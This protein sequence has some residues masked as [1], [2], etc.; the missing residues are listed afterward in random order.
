VADKTVVVRIALKGQQ[1]SQGLKQAAADTNKFAVDV[2]RGADNAGQS[3]LALGAA[4][5]TAGKL[6]VLGIGGAMVVSAAAAIEYQS[7]LT[8]V[9]KTTG[10]AG[11]T[12]ASA[13]SELATFG[14]AMRNLSL[15]I[16][17]NV[18]ELNRIAELGGQLGVAVPS[19][20]GFTETIAMLG[21]TTN[22]ATEEAATGLARF[23]NIMGTPHSEFGRLGDIIVDL[24]N[25]FAATESEI[26]KFATRIAPVGQTV[27]ATEEEVMALATSLTSLG[28]PAERGG[29][30]VQRLFIDMASAIDDAGPKL[31]KFAEVA[32]MT[33]EEF[34][35]LFGESPARAF[36]EFARGLDNVSE[37]GGSAFQTLRELGIN[38]QRTIQV[39]LASASGWETIADAIDTANRAGQEGTALQ[40]E[41][42]LRFGTTASELQLLA[43]AFNDLR[44]EVG[45]AILG[46]G[47]LSVAVDVVREFFGIVKDNLPTIQ[48][49]ATVMG[50]LATVRMGAWLAGLIPQAIQMGRSLMTMASGANAASRGMVAVKLASLGLTTAMY[51]AL[52]IAGLLAIKWANAAIEAAE[53]RRQARLL[54]EEIGQ[55]VDPVDAFVNSLTEADILSGDMVETLQKYGVST[56]DFVEAL[57]EGKSAQEVLNDIQ[58]EMLGTG[59]LWEDE[60]GRLRGVTHEVATDFSDIAKAVN[61]SQDQVEAFMGLKRS[62]LHDVLIDTG[63]AAN[64]T[65]DEIESL[66][67]RALQM[68]GLDISETEF[69]KWVRG[70]FA[71]DGWMAQI[72]DM[73]QALQET[74]D[75]KSW[76]EKL[77]GT[78]EGADQ[79]GDFF[80][81]IM[82][83]LG[84]YSEFITEKMD[85]VAESVYSQFPA[86]DEY[87]QV[88]IESLDAVIAAQDKFIEDLIVATALEEELRGEL[89]PA[90]LDWFSNLDTATQAGLARFREG[91]QTA[92]DQFI[93]DLNSNFDEAGGVVGEKWTNRLPQ[94][95]QEGFDM[96]IAGLAENVDAMEL[97]GEDNAEAFRDGLVE[98]LAGLPQTHQPL[99][100]QY[101]EDSLHNP[102]LLEG[103]G[104]DMGDALIRGLLMALGDMAVRAY[105]EIGRQTGKIRGAFEDGFMVESPSKFTFWIGTQLTEGLVQGLTQSMNTEASRI[106]RSFQPAMNTML[107]S[108]SH[109][110]INVPKQPVGD[111]A[112]TYNNPHM[113]D[114][115]KDLKRTKLILTDLVHLTEG[116]FV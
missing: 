15:D 94:Y 86:W 90:A 36:Q 21:V 115:S 43:N 59:E 11:E 28:V 14:Q 22:L 7:S 58:A 61:R 98:I 42:A 23:A 29:T 107:N 89:S 19:L 30:A 45:N 13:G 63:K 39:L 54:N 104:F 101:L 84:E 1:F 82:D 20:V 83:G 69:G 103:L 81:S 2:S 113:V 49:L 12:F 34:A 57:L 73:N 74:A 93:D 50:I 37:S 5:A 105:G 75:D 17:I 32:G 46:S 87:E 68:F 62:E 40:E 100:M 60:A 48:N 55:G 110:T 31:E 102:A 3:A 41:A 71:I 112:L 95:A 79:V 27:G 106:S 76:I 88:V 72:G 70:E 52:A 24:G 108:A 64:M 65:D 33:G 4:S 85:E 53:L 44:I 91:N 47:G 80:G 66:I 35:E 96:M 16:P 18:N 10:L 67:D 26:L 25:N 111:I 56:R 9:A 92:F 8:G 38:E 116:R 6:M 99:F 77:M 114:Y 109:T 97:T 51:G 78:E